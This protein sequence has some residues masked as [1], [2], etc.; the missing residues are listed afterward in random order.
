MSVFAAIGRGRA[1]SPLQNML[2]KKREADE[3]QRLRGNDPRLKLAKIKLGREQERDK[4]RSIPKTMT[5]IRGGLSQYAPETQ[6]FIMKQMASIFDEQGQTTSGK[7]DDWLTKNLN[8]D[9]RFSVA[10]AQK[11]R[12]FYDTIYR[13]AKEKWEKLKENDKADTTAG[14]AAKKA[15]DDASLDF[16]NL[17]KAHA[18]MVKSAQG[19]EQE[20]KTATLKREQALADA[21][22]ERKREALI[23]TREQKQALERIRVTAEE[24]RKTG[25]EKP[26]AIK[27]TLTEKLEFEKM[28]KSI[29]TDEKMAQI[30]S[31]IAEDVED[32]GV[33]GWVTLYN[34]NSDIDQWEWIKKG[35]KKIGFDA[36][37]W[38][39]VSKGGVKVGKGRE[40][41]VIVRRGIYMGR[42]I[43]QYEDG[44]TDYVD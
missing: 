16:A 24:A 39:K 7:L 31:K 27:P 18:A 1:L 6:D 11:E 30:N 33:A 42:K 19:F 2:D 8:K 25:R 43:V 4:A 14:R 28:K 12:D 23:D 37:G 36:D 3:A 41:K 9:S 20:K 15:M 10:I 32:R 13:D 26:K 5:E 44:T 34:K 29:I 40:P 21:K 35:I 17:D 38:V 22:E